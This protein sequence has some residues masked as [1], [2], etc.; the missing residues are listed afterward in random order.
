MK[1]KPNFTYPC[2][3]DT[4]SEFE[5]PIDC[6]F[7]LQD[8]IEEDELRRPKELDENGERCLLV[9]KNGNGT[10]VTIGRATGPMS[11]VREYFEDGTHETSMMLAIYGYGYGDKSYGN[12]ERK[13]RVFSGPSDSGSIIV[14]R[15]GRVVGLLTGGAGTTGSTNPDVTYV[16]PFY[17]LLQ[18]IKTHFPNAHLYQAMDEAS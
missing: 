1:L 11:F 2:S 6:L 13:E 5:Y 4:T 3:V 14:N 7:T 17:W 8:V 9:I 18:R 15:K 12:T 16:T 10:G